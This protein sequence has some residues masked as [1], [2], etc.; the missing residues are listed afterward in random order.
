MAKGCG[1]EIWV[2]GRDRLCHLD[3]GTFNPIDAEYVLCLNCT[4]KNEETKDL[5][6]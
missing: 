4:E 2:D 5:N 1:K 6:T 3:C